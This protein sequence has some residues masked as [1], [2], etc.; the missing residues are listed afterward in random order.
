MKKTGFTLVELLIVIALIAIL[1]V[2]VLATINPIEQANKAKDSSIQNDA[3]EMLNAYERFYAN[4]QKYPWEGYSDALSVDSAVLLSSINPGFGI[5]YGAGGPTGVASTA[6]AS[7]AC[8]TSG[9]QLG[10][11]V[12]SDELKGAF[13]SKGAFK[14]PVLDENKLWTVKLPGSGASIYVC[15]I[16]KAKSNRQ[17]VNKLMCIDNTVGNINIIPTT[18]DAVVGG[19]APLGN[20]DVGWAIPDFNG[21]KGMFRCVPE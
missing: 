9:N 15:Y 11:L 20:G 19:C 2:A 12:Q 18:T 14:N 5:C 10:K 16:P 8:N 13:A 7:A 1:S 21:Q 4:A 17:M 6:D 3:A